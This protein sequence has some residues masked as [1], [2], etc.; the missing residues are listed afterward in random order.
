MR[1]TTAGILVGLLLTTAVAVTA[2][3]SSHRDRL[4]SVINQAI[5]AG[6]F[7]TETRPYEELFTE[8]SLLQMQLSR[9]EAVV[10]DVMRSVWMGATANQQ[11]CD[12]VQILVRGGPPIPEAFDYI[13]YPFGSRFLLALVLN[14]TSFHR[15]RL[16]P[17]RP[18]M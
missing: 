12:I 6:D 17:D 11:P 8:C 1:K 7:I 9:H 5:D 14:E 10:T 3:L 18:K 16:V 4:V 2:N 13:N 15:A